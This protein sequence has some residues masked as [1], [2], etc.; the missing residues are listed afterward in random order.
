MATDPLSV[1]SAPSTQDPYARVVWDR[2][3]PDEKAEAIRDAEVWRRGLQGSVEAV[4]FDSPEA[5]LEA[6]GILPDE[7]AATRPDFRSAATIP[8]PTDVGAWQIEG[9]LRPRS[10][11][12]VGAGEGVGKTQLLRE[13]AIRGTTGTGRLFGHY[14]IPRRL[15]VMTLDEENGEAEEYRRETMILDALG[16]ERSALAD[17]FRVSF[18]GMVLTDQGAQ[19]WL[20]SQVDGIRPDLLVL[21]TGTSMVGDEWGTELKAA[22]RYAR[23]LIVRYGC[24]VAILVHLTKPARDRRP[25]SPAHGS[26]LSDVMGQWTRTADSVALVADLGEGRLRWEMRKKVPPST[27]ILAKRSG[28][29]DVVSVGEASRGPSSDDRVLRAIAA[30]GAGPEEIAKVLGLAKRTVSDAIA[31]LRKDGLIGPGHPYALTDDGREALE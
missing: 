29:F 17:Y 19:E 14:A 31:R 12:I 11:L 28:V 10:L 27:L 30:G 2:L 5:Y 8:E 3:T 13:L 1:H 6:V 25:G 16:L 9:V 22:I 24:S 23:S 7:P 18:A 26:A 21:D 4:G 15:R 20:A